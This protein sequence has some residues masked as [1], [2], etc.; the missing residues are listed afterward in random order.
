MCKEKIE[1]G[2]LYRGQSRTYRYCPLTPTAMRCNNIPLLRTNPE[3]AQLVS[4]YSDFS[5][6]KTTEWYKDIR[7]ITD[8]DINPFEAYFLSLVNLCIAIKRNPLLKKFCKAPFFV[9]TEHDFGALDCGDAS[10]VEKCYTYAKAM[11]KNTEEK[12]TL[13]NY[14]NI[15]KEDLSYFQHL[16]HVFNRLLGY[17]P[18]P[19]MMLDWTDNLDIAKKF[20]KNKKTDILSIDMK[21]YFDFLQAGLK[22]TLDFSKPLLPQIIQAQTIYMS[23]MSIDTDFKNIEPNIMGLYAYR[24]HGCTN[25]L[26][27]DQQGVTI[28]WPWSFTPAELVN[29]RKEG[30]GLGYSLDFKIEADN[31]DAQ[32]DGSEQDDQPKISDYYPCEKCPPRDK[33]L[34]ECGG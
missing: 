23:G 33:F 4:R 27:I 26:M 32:D 24:M 25:Q 21:K 17:C 11:F 3:Y 31:P 9:D 6:E 19:T 28:F 14:H 20:V 13:A 18:F 2:R 16:N 30:K 8:L 10:T 15:I 1:A 34:E 29:Q 7:G 5:P 12:Q 22:V